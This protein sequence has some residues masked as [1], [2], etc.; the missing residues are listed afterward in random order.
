MRNITRHDDG[1]STWTCR[2]GKTVTRY[3]GQS[4]T[5]CQCGQWYNACGQQ[6]RSNWMENPSNY[7]ENVSDMEGYELSCGDY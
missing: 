7:D 3:R 6:L 1:S 4:D 2:C 5:R